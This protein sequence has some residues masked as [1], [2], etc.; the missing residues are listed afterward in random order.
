MKV[1]KSV[2]DIIKKYENKSVLITGGTGISFEK[3]GF[4]FIGIKKFSKENCYF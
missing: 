1:I 2:K 3:N 4:T